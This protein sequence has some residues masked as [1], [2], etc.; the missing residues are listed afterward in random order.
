MLGDLR[1]V[2]DQDDGDS[3]LVELLKDGHHFEGGAAIEITGRF[4]GQQ[5]GRPVDQRAGNGHALLLAA[6]KL[7]GIVVEAVS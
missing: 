2:G 3:L 6:G 1:L 7:G 5:Q 4:I